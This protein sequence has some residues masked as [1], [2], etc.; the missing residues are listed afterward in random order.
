MNEREKK[1]QKYE[2]EIEQM[3]N[4]RKKRKDEAMRRERKRKYFINIKKKSV[5]KKL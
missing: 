2:S 5:I 1:E 3:I 4:E